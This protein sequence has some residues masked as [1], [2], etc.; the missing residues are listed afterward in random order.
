MPFSIDN[1]KGHVIKSSAEEDTKVLKY[2][3]ELKASKEPMT[4]YQKARL[5]QLEKQEAQEAKIKNVGLKQQ[6]SIFNNQDVKNTMKGFSS[7]FNNKE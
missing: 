4:G 3:R 5:E 7:I 1:I 2:L 6:P